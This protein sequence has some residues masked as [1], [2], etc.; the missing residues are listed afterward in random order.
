ME[1]E[2]SSDDGWSWFWRVEP[3]HWMK[4]WRRR[5]RVARRPEV[6]A[7]SREESGLSLRTETW[8]A[9]GGRIWLVKWRERS[10]RNTRVGWMEVAG[11]GGW[12]G[13]AGNTLS[14]YKHLV[15]VDNFLMVRDNRLKNWECHDRI[16]HADIK[17]L[18]LSLQS[19]AVYEI[20]WNPK[21]RLSKEALFSSLFSIKIL[22][23]LSTFKYFHT[24]VIALWFFFLSACI[25]A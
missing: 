25:F 6:T 2:G 22:S 9:V 3:S 18:L 19:E 14:C 1:E 20:Q 11:R 13:A 15:W 4:S 21:E 24:F 8:L 7:D 17:A 23:Y 12:R 16:L 10:R 5:R